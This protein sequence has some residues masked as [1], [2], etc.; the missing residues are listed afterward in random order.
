MGGRGSGSGGGGLGDSK[1]KDIKILE[2]IDVWSYRHRQ[3]NEP[4]VDAINGGVRT[5][6]NDFPTVMND[7]NFVNTAKFGGRDGASA[8]GVWSPADKQL[9]IAKKYTDVDKMNRIYD[10]GGEYHPSRG[11]KSA[12][13]AVTL[14]EMGHALNDHIAA[15][16]GTDLDSAAK[17]IV[18]NAYKN[19]KATG[20]TKAWAGKIS[21][22]ATES[23]A[24]CIAEAV[25]DWYCN[26][27]RANSAS[28][29]IMSELRRAYNS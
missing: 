9:A 22:Y 14:H 29:A 7:V 12:V 20:G 19:S 13:E 5:I 4:F 24:E 15:K 28:K 1:P 21:G 2:P 6:S 8:L 26:G 16:M 23:N 3:K 17:S 27:N 25:C 10:Q 11:N 18:N